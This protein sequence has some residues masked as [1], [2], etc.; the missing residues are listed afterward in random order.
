MSTV[1]PKWARAHEQW[2]VGAASVEPTGLKDLEKYPGVFLG[3]P[4]TKA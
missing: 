4:V 3:C 1:A 2:A